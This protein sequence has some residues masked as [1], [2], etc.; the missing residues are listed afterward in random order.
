MRVRTAMLK[1]QMRRLTK[2]KVERDSNTSLF[3][4]RGA[5]PRL[6]TVN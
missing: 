3:D 6:A 2:E 4:H 5:E 1:L